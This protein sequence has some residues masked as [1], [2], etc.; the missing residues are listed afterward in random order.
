[1]LKSDPAEIS[2][3]FGNSP[4]A[5]LELGD[6]DIATLR[7][8]EFAMPKTANITFK[9]DA[10]GGKSGGAQVGKIYHLAVN[11][12]PSAALERVESAGDPFVLELPTANKKNVNLAIGV[13][14]DKAKVK[15]TIVAPKRIDESRNVAVFELTTLASGWMHVTTKPVAA[16]K[17]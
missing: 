9:I 6:K 14:D 3:T 16:A 5:K 7:I 8:P 17:K 11:F 10:R 1:M 15:W 13:E 12:P 2:D 4:G